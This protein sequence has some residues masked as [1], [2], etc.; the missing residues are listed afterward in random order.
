M[1]TVL[2]TTG[3]TV[4]FTS[5]IETILT[6]EFISSLT[7]AGVTNLIIQYG[8]EI[9]HSKHISTQFFKKQLESSDLVSCGKFDASQDLNKIVLQND[10]IKIVAFPYDSNISDF[11]NKSDVVI[12]HAGTGSIIDTLRNNKKLIVVVNDKLM[13]NHQSEIANE[14]AKLQYCLSYAVGDLARDKFFDGL[15]GLL[16]DEIM[17]K[18]FP[19]VDGSI[20]ETV[21]S[22]ELEK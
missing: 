8:N 6:P 22:E 10:S 1:A 21:I 5:L 19:E 4:T 12:S 9:K 2:V 3:A 17:L 11:I 14:F 16:N 18:R 20:V 7:N 13:D 15:K